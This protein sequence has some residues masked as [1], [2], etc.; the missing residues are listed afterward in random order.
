MLA[1]GFRSPSV[2][3]TPIA[4]SSVPYI[5]ESRRLGRSGPWQVSMFNP[6]NTATTL[7]STGY[8]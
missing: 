6:G 7:T 3:N 8:C 1:G 4:G 5:Y 2:I